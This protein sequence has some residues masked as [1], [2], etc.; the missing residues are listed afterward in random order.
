MEGCNE[1]LY[2]K[3]YENLH[4]MYPLQWLRINLNV[5][6][7]WGNVTA[8]FQEFVLWRFI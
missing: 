8:S 4:H 7:V 5:N 6:A 1:E 2:E 3:D